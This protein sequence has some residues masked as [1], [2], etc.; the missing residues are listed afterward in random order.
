MIEKTY[1]R[2]TRAFIAKV[3]HYSNEAIRMTVKQIPR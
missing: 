2:E 3:L 1:P